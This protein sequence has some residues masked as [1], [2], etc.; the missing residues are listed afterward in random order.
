MEGF[1]VCIS[2]W[3]RACGVTT[4]YL[5]KAHS[6]DVATTTV[7]VETRNLGN[8]NLGFSD[9]CY[10]FPFI[11]FGKILRK[12]IGN[13]RISGRIT[14]ELSILSFSKTQQNA[15]TDKNAYQ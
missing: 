4:A 8:G 9:S 14:W 15:L 6:F 12:K 3:E 13:F 5:A 2:L 1:F 7:D 10:I 11:A